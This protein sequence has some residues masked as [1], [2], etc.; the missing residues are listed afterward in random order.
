MVCKCKKIVLCALLS[1]SLFACKKETKDTISLGNWLKALQQEAHIE[2]TKTKKPYFL[3]I[4]K[5]HPQFEIVQ[6]AVDWKIVEEGIHFDL[7]KSLTKEWLAYTLVNLW[8]PKKELSSP[9]IKDKDKSQFPKHIEKAVSLGIVDVDK[10]QL[11][12]PQEVLE[13]KKAIEILKKVVRYLDDKEV[14]SNQGK[15]EWKEGM[16]VQEIN[17]SQFNEKEKSFHLGQKSSIKKGTILKHKENYYR[18]KRIAD[19]K[20]FLESINPLEFTEKIDLSG[21]MKVDW[22][23]ASVQPISEVLQPMAL[24]SSSY[25]KPIQIFGYQGELRLDSSGVYVRAEKQLPKKAKAFVQ[26]DVSG[27]SLKYDWHSRGLRIP[28]AYVRF[29]FQS[30]QKAGIEKENKKSYQLNPNLNL[31]DIQSY[32]IPKEHFVKARIP[33]CSIQVPIPQFPSLN[34][35]LS[36]VAELDM[37]GYLHF[38]LQQMNLLGFQIRNSHI[39]WISNSSQQNYLQSNASASVLANVS[40]ALRLAHYDLANVGLKAGIQGRL[41]DKIVF[42]DSYRKGQELE[43]PFDEQIQQKEGIRYCKD[44]S[45]NWLLEVFFNQENSFLNR[46]GMKANFPLL[47]EK[48]ATIFKA[49]GNGLE[50]CRLNPPRDKE[51]I[52]YRD[53][54]ALESLSYTVKKGQV[55]SV[56]LLDLPSGYSLK[57]VEV[58]VVH[59]EIIE[60]NFLLFKGLQEGASSIRIQ[61]KDQEHTVYISI[62]VVS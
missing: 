5:N 11:F 40:L 35:H 19:K 38:S 45:A 20:A 30:N 46:L 54:F 7:E 59:P 42:Y 9:S 16:D 37:Q 51:A 36:L 57:D 10:H 2:A 15:V 61:T 24:K 4:Q 55:V 49:K 44:Y 34:V 50:A 27:L 47:N 3:H 29:R 25:V 13:K 28:D 58:K 6:T 41:K 60:N 21:E 8:E 43:G 33:L 1:L 14:K 53:G 18:I 32:L 31:R 62:M 12:H 26:M 17:S 48:Q 23:K 22:S 52:H 56:E 39:R